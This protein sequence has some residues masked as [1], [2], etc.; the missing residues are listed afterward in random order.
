MKDMQLSP[1]R[2]FPLLLV[3][4]K[5]AA[6]TAGQAANTDRRLKVGPCQVAF[7][8]GRYGLV[9]SSY[10][11]E[12]S[13]GKPSALHHLRRNGWAGLNGLSGLIFPVF[14]LVGGLR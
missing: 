9:L 6:S 7:D 1:A 4:E 3:L 2:S 14:L 10:Q 11:E 13:C 12:T 8:R 5:G